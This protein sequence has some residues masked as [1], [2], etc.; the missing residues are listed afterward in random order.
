MSVFWLSVF[1][2]H[3]GVWVGRCR[4]A[5]RGNAGVHGSV[6]AGPRRHNLSSPAHAAHIPWVPS[7]PIISCSCCSHSMSAITTYHLLLMLLTFRECHHN[8]SSP[9][10]ASHSTCVLPSL[11]QIM[12]KNILQYSI[13]VHSKK[14]LFN[15]N[16]Q[17]WQLLNTRMILTLLLG[18]KT[19]GPVWFIRCV[20]TMLWDPCSC[21]IY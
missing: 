7:Q 21:M 15:C 12:N 8:Q 3:N 13:A 17:C 18:Y 14:Q 1:W 10:H 4:W 20:N 2:P 6:Q 9:A 5:V 11:A 19:R 16:E